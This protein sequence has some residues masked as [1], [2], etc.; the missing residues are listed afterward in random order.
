MDKILITT[1]VGLDC[2]AS[3]PQKVIHLVAGDYGTRAL[4]LV[5]VSSGALIRMD[6]AGVTAAKVRL[7]CT[8]REVLLIDCTLGDVYAELVPTEAMVSEADT[9]QAQLVL[10]D[11]ANM[12][13]SAS[14]FEI[15][16]H[17]T[18]YQGDAVEHTDASVLNVSYDSQ[19]YL[20]LEKASGE[21]LKANKTVQEAHT[22]AEATAEKAGFMSAEDK[23]ALDGLSGLFDQGLKTTDS[24]EFAGL[25]IG[26]LTIDAEGN[27]RGARFT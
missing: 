20:C 18:V 5:P 13:L 24:P 6:E 11:E 25:T 3:V 2:D 10:L 22:H 14:P 26:G 8:G 17:G 9:W 7:A 15:V 19:G 21:I 23:A 16:V 12:T 27:I 4:R 1:T